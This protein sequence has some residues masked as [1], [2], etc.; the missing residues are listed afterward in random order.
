MLKC[1][2]PGCREAVAS[3]T[4]EN[5]W[6]FISTGDERTSGYYCKNHG[7]ALEAVEDGEQD[8][9]WP[10]CSEAATYAEMLGKWGALDAE[11]FLCAD[12]SE[13]FEHR[14][15]VFDAPDALQ[16]FRNLSRHEPDRQAGPRRR[17]K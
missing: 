1:I 14:G 5:G 15:G 10:G 8:C 11:H 6:S 17:E 9:C 3:R 2:F 4:E 16:H 13:E 12:H 7:D